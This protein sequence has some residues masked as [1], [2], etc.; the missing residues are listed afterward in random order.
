MEPVFDKAFFLK[1]ILNEICIEFFSQL[2]NLFFK[3]IIEFSEI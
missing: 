2:G 1:D 3:L